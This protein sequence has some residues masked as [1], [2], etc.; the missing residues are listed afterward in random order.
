MNKL[1]VKFVVLLV[2]TITVVNAEE[3]YLNIDA[4]HFESDTQ[5]NIL[6]FNGDVKMTKNKD[7]LL[8]QKLV[9]NTEAS[10]VDPKKQIPKD[11]KATGNVSFVLYTVDNVLKGKGDIVYY[12]PNEK[13]YI[14]IGNGF[15]EDTKEG[16][17]INAEK[18]YIDELTGRTKIDG[19]KNKPIQFRLRL[20]PEKET[21]VKKDSN[22]TKETKTTKE[23]K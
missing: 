21:T 5:K 22:V 23:K 20:N 10:P 17:K 15:L 9:I 1:L 2:L 3:N 4:K 11:Y 7:I 8:C 13:R 6:H 18:I 12:Y 19:G 16:K 14:I